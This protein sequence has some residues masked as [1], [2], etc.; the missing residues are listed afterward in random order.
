MTSA[1][2]FVI[3]PA[4]DVAGGRVS[5][6]PGASEAAG[7]A[8]QAA[9]GARDPAE[10]R[11]PAEA[12]DTNT[13]AAVQDPLELALRYL[14]EGADWIHLVD[15][16]AAFDRGSNAE[17]LADVV[18]RVD[19]DVQLAGGIRDERTLQAALRTG[20]A[21]VVLGTEAVADQDW[22]RSA[23]GRYGDRIA[24]ALDVNGDRLAPRGSGR[25]DGSLL[26]ALAAL[27][28]DGARRYVVTDVTRDGTMTGPNLTLLRR[29]CSM[30]DRAVLASGGV[31]NLEHLRA[32]SALRGVGG[33][34]VGGALAAGS[35]ELSEALA[36][37]AG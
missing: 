20:A 3:L 5:R 17:L 13:V 9:A 26:D 11:D 14:R 36:T 19:V 15:L 10:P 8:R 24:V 6:P 18:R 4:V 16:D 35:L 25:V 1:P 33:A 34:V 29:V 37:V 27:D 2:P 31:G 28:A 12:A 22:V 23:I 7:G 32:L 30:T 21:R